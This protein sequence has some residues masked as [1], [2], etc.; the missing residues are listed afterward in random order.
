MAHPHTWKPCCPPAP[1]PN[2]PQQQAL[3]PKAKRQ[4]SDPL[5]THA[6]PLSPAPVAPLAGG[7]LPPTPSMQE[8]EEVVGRL[9]LLDQWKVLTNI[10][11]VSKG[12]DKWCWVGVLHMAAILVHG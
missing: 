1:T 8:A 7:P 2:T 12:R 11:H 4:R 3:G 9:P 5:L 6:E 10:V